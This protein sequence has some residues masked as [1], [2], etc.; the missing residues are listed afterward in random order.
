MK[1]TFTK[2]LA[3]VLSAAMIL[4]MVPMIAFAAEDFSMT[5]ASTKT[6]ALAPGVQEQEVVAYDANGDRV[7]YYAITAN[8][9]TNSDVQVK[10]NYQNND[11]T[12]NWGKAT[13][14]EQANAATAKRGYN[15]VATTNASYYN[16]STGQPTGA[17]FMEGVNVNGDAAGNS[18]PFFAILKDG[19]AMIGQKGTFSQYSDQVQEAVGGWQMLVW[20]GQIVNNG[21]TKYP[22]STIGVKANG[23]VVMMVADGNQKPYSAGLT[24]R[25]QAEVMLSLGCVA[26]VELDGGGSATYAAKLEGTDELVIRNSC[27]DGTVR[28]VSNTLMVIS[29]AVAD[30]T[31]DHANLAT[32]YVYY[33]PYSTVE[34][35]ATGADKSG[36]PAEIPEGATWTLSD[37]SFG[38]VAD[39][40]FVSNGKLGTVT[41]SMTVD[42]AV[43]GST[44]VTVVHPTSV[45]FQAEEKMIP[46]GKPSDFTLTALYNGADMYAAA[47][48]Y[49]FN[50]PLGSMNGFVY[51]APEECATTATTVTA[52]Y[53]YDA[54][55]PADSIEVTFGKGSDILFDFEGGE[56]DAKYWGTYFDM[57]E[58]E[59]NGDYDN[60]YSVAYETE[61]STMGNLVGNGV[62][63]N[64]FL[65][66]K[67]NGKVYSGDY[68]LAYTVDY[69]YSEAHANWQYAYLYYWGEPIT[70][71]DT[72]N[73]IAGTRLGMWMY[74]P[75]EAV[76]SCA[77]FAY[78]YKDANGNLSTA[79][80]YLTYMYVE[81][82]FSK[83]TSDKIPEAGW[84]YVYV[85]MKQISNTYVSTSYYKTED[86]TLTRAADSNYAPAFIQFIVSSSATGAEKVTFYIDDITL[87]YSDA[88]DDRDMP[89]V[90][91]PLL[92]EDQK[93]YAL[94]G[95]T[96]N[97]NTITVTASAAE[98]TSRGT[99]FTGLNESTAQ[100]YVDGH[101]VATKFAAGKISATGIT[102]ADGTHDITF[103][104]AD[105]QGN[106]TKLTKQI[107]ID[108][109]SDYPSV[110][111]TGAPAAVNKDGN[112][113][114]G[115]QYNMFLNTDTVEN[116][117]EVNFQLWLNSASEWALEEMTVLDGFDV[118]Y[119]L[120][121]NSCT[122]DITVTR[123]DSDATGEATLLTIPVYAWSWNEE[124]GGHTATYQ[125]NTKG[126][127]PQTTVSYKVKYGN[128][129][130]VEDVTATNYVAGFSNKRTDVKTEL[131]SSIANL[132][133]TIGEWHYH[134]EVAVDDVANTCTEDG[135]TGRTK[136]SVCES[137]ITWGTTKATGHDYV[138]TDGV[139]A[140]ACG[141]KFNGEKDGATYIDGIAYVNGWYNDTYYFVNGKKVTGPYVIDRVVYVFGEDGVYQPDGLF[142][143]FI[144]TDEGR[145]YFLSNTDY[146]EDFVYISATPH[147]FED[148]VLRNGEY[149]INGETCQFKD[150]KFVACTTADVYS[151]GWAGPECF[152]I[153]YKDGRFVFTG[154]GG[155]FYHQSNSSVPWANEKF[156]ITSVYIPKD[157]TEI[158]RFAF[159]HSYYIT[160]I[161]IEEG[162]KLETIRY[163]AFHYVNKIKKFALPDTVKKIEWCA[164][165]Y[166]QSL[167]TMYLPDGLT[168]I[169]KDAFLKANAGAIYQVAEGTPAHTYAVNKGFNVELR[170]KKPVLLD[171]GSCGENLTWE[172]YDTGVL[173][174]N[175]TG[176]MN[177]FHYA[178]YNANAA[179]WALNREKIQK[180]VIGE[181]VTSIGEFAFYQCTALTE[182]EFAENSKLETIGAGAFGYDS[183]LKTVTLPASLKV[184]EKNAFYYSALETVAFE[185]GAKLT[186]IG[187]YA[188]R[189]CTALK[190]V[191]IPDSTTSLGGSIYY[192]CGDQV[193]SNV[194]EDSSAYRYVVKNGYA[195]E[196]R[197]ALP[198]VKYEGTAGDLTWTLYDNG[199]LE[200]GGYG[201]MAD[202]H[203][204]KHNANAAPWALYRSDITKVVIGKGVQNIG[205][206]AF[207]QC[208]ALTEVTF[209]EG[210]TLTDI[211]AGA[212]GYLSA[213]KSITL[214]A[215]LKTIDKNA[216]YYSALETVA[217][218][219]GA[220]LTTIGNYAFRNN[221]ALKSFYIPDSTT[222]LGSAIFYACGDQVVVNVA[223]DSSAYR[224]AVK[225]GYAYVTREPQPVVKY[226]GTCGEGLTWALYDNGTLVIG[227]NG[228]MNSFH[229]AK[230]NDNAAPWALYRSDIT[231]V[232]IGKGVKSIGDYAFY[233]CTALTEVVFEEGSTL[234]YIYAGAFGYDSALKSI[235]LPASVLVIDK[236]AF[237]YSALETVAFEDGAKLV[238]IG[239]YA[240]RNCTALKNVYIPSSVASIGSAMYYACNGVVSSVAAN[241]YA[242]RYMTAQGY[243]FTAR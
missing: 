140:C 126:C 170:E 196:T 64:V 192:A 121:E 187:N 92:L 20:D 48:A 167:Q 234:T 31:F 21:T 151:A 179:P 159:A 155:M 173:Y 47:D 97:Y 56:E 81:K 168:D 14:I 86:G 225:Q 202:Y 58:A 24:Y 124:L 139:L 205:E 123:V 232:V 38:T 1:S 221:T 6:S 68:S 2:V 242:A 203:Y 165:G 76:G 40:K 67:T 194:A 237:Y 60:G 150:G 5:I 201:T 235:T 88:V 181:G 207:Y 223:A 239:D 218:E 193:V 43:V 57:V 87:D 129:E 75:E 91:D 27:C 227:G 44:D 13:V 49:N 42:G 190:N 62:H 32:D 142:S 37:D 107:V 29:T 200:I 113:Y 157:I 18:Y 89:I 72:E 138:L 141:E 125:W 180:V 145:M 191:F 55:V 35:N 171:S 8:V 77:R 114:T 59:K 132:K 9:A 23:D 45:A 137:I 117:K 116:I 164:F 41:V 80:L 85:D 219:D 169:Q 16:V 224:Y 238:S 217:F 243:A 231:K 30:G 204:A 83:L 33:A 230:Y 156:N 79:Y 183:A 10:A 134:T 103:E 240:F 19:T 199:T 177:D 208:T 162:S 17:F 15:V 236:C 128:V 152:F 198:V 131:N 233:Q 172:L 98:D 26:A 149:V 175:G 189:N 158:C 96:I 153:H 188:F 110:T 220:K 111:L 71:L 160:N 228:S 112:M 74:I 73:G 133:K 212:F 185:D 61:G 161:T 115:G 7:V 3:M 90:S 206:F 52:S 36:F 154:K 28:S 118:E 210:C 241:S 102:L 147:Y 186:T 12:G 211:G 135:Y 70:L 4:G 66:D 130:Y 25:E 93:S 176:D 84:A 226:E 109:G 78:T 34:V 69:R 105:K 209:A 22:R 53:K 99:N 94:N 216:F 195:Y 108:A 163:Q 65:A 106:Y 100:V 11:N 213:L 136:C 101:K 182:V 50:C 174:V 197:E 229:Y 119:V 63:E 214:P 143:G 82:G 104:I 51:T 184:I 148:G 222:E 39:G 95:Q 215:S 54:T 144:D 178:K 166:W 146:V 127:A 46:Y 120:D 122:A